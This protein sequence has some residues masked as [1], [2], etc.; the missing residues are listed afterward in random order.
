MRGELRKRQTKQA[1]EEAKTETL[2]SKKR[3]APLVLIDDL[4][5]SLANSLISKRLKEGV[6]L[7]LNAGYPL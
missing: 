1:G 6:A 5:F 7:L 4:V 3:H 2:V